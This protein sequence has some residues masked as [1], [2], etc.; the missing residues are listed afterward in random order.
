MILSNK[1]A[2]VSGASKGIGKEIAISLAKQG[3]KVIVH[4]NQSNPNETLDE[5]K[6]FGG[7]CASAQCNFL[8]GLDHA[9]DLYKQ[10]Q[11]IFGTINI[12]INNAAIGH[13]ISIKNTSE[14]I[15]DKMFMVNTKIPY[16]LCKTAINNMPTGGKII[17]ISGVGTRMMI[18]NF[19]CYLAT[20]GALEQIT[21][22]LA[23]EAAS[24]GISI[25]AIAPGATKTDM[26]MNCNS[27]EVLESVAQ[28][29][30]YKR[31]GMPKDIAQI[32]NFLSSDESSWITGQ[33]IHANGGMM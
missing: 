24:E 28:M 13:S 15:F 14:D 22:N 19:S 7:I 29:I 32:A 8:D 12:L 27:D 6:A 31:L 20:K 18:P 21:R 26:L 2:L 4:F 1:I 25:N 10:A 9:L 17:N 5:I 30:A 33:V 23:V 3:A 16:F 11:S